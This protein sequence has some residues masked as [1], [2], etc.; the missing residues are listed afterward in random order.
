MDLDRTTDSNNA[1]AE[2]YIR[3]ETIQCAWPARKRAKRFISIKKLFIFL[4]YEKGC[5]CCDRLQDKIQKYFYRL[6]KNI[7]IV[8]NWLQQRF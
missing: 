4:K 2:V 1:E 6:Y 8:K 7:L 3:P 5:M